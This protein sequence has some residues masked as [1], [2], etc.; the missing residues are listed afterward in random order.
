MA[1]FIV[2]A[3]KSTF[4]EVVDGKQKRIAKARF[5]SI[6]T[7]KVVKTV[8]TETETVYHV[9]ER[10]TV[11]L[12]SFAELSENV[13][14]AIVENNRE[15][16]VDDAY[17]YECVKDDFH[18]TLNLL[19]FSEVE[20][21]F[22]GF[23]SQGDGASFTA[24]FEAANIVNNTEKWQSDKAFEYFKPYLDK[25]LEIGGS[26]QIKR[27]SSLYVH[28]KTCFIDDA[29]EELEGTL[30]ELRVW[31]CNKYYMNLERE[32]DYLTSD[33]SIYDYLLNCDWLKYTKNGLCVNI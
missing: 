26:A 1:N 12:F 30:E 23:Y 22:S 7:Q 28:E 14:N 25:L 6:M 5:D 31:L 3:K 15:V 13:Q 24:F 27:R 18:E 33:N 16:L 32:Y 20:S 2:I 21:C 9:E 29:S 11:E 4:W 19:G 8:K 10:E 17:W